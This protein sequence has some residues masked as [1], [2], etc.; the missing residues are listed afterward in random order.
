MQRRHRQR[1]FLSNPTDFR[2]ISPSVIVSS[3]IRGRHAWA[4]PIWSLAVALLV[5]APS[6]RA[7]GGPKLISTDALAAPSVS[8]DSSAPTQTIVIG[9]L[10]G[11]VR[12]DDTVHSE[13]QLAQ[14][15]RS[16]YPAGVRVQAF[17]N[18]RRDD[19]HKW[20]LSLV[21]AQQAGKPTEDQKR[22]AR[23]ILYGHSWGANAVVALARDLETDGIPVLLTVQVDS[24]AKAGQN[25]GVIPGNVARAVNFYQD[26]GFLHGQRQIR[27]ADA[28]RTQILGNFRMDYAANPIACP[29]Y[30]WYG[31]IFMRSHIE[32]ECDP[33]V[34][35]RIET[36]IREQ[37]P[38]QVARAGDAR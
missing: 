26:R 4:L 9:F 7:Q 35:R 29:Q 20:I 28:T 16:E 12:H 14:R 36:L 32:I 17:E 22:A 30:P 38:A 13:V 1:S 19:A 3:L 5:L 2:V 18:R 31:R 23:V 25:D 33:S 6:V 27:A 8:A 21:A 11:F 10:G 37:L 34:W 15:L 24:I